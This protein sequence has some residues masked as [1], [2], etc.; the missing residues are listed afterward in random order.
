MDPRHSSREVPKT[1]LFALAHIPRMT[2][3]ILY[4]K[5]FVIPEGRVFENAKVLA[6]FATCE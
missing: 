2:F 3:V 5:T 1:S 4:L 6:A